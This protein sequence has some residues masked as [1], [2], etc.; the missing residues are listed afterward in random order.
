MSHAEQS[1]K[2]F[3]EEQQ[4]NQKEPGLLDEILDVVKDPKRDKNKK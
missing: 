3:N 2:Q 1:S 4:N